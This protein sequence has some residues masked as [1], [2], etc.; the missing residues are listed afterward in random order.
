L[1]NLQKRF[2][3]KNK[4][5]EEKS[6]IT[7]FIDKETKIKVLEYGIILP[8]RRT[9]K[10]NGLVSATYEGGVSDK[11]GNFVAGLIRNLNNPNFNYNCNESYKVKKDNLEYS[12]ETVIFGGILFK[13]F[14][15]VYLDTL[16]RLWWVI[17]NPDK[18]YRLVFV[19]IPNQEFWCYDFFDMLN[20]PRNRIVI[21]NKPT[22]FKKIIIPD[23][24]I[25]SQSGFKSEFFTII[26]TISSSVKPSPYKKIYLTRSQLEEKDCINEEYFENFYKKRGYKVISPEKYSVKEQIAFM[27]GAE[28]VV[29]TVGTLSHNILFSKKNITL[30]MLTRVDNLLIPQI[31]INEIKNI[32]YFIIDVTKNIL[33]TTHVKGCF[34]LH[35]SKFWIEYLDD[36]KIDYMK[37]EIEFDLDEFL[38]IYLKQWCKNYSLKSR[39]RRIERNDI[40]HVINSLSIAFYDKSLSRKNMD[41]PKIQ[42]K[43]ALIR[44]NKKLKIEI[45][46]LKK[47]KK[48]LSRLYI[49]LRKKLKNYYIAQKLYSIFKK[50]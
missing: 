28:E 10:S 50:K 24:S 38:P 3:T 31:I 39:Y 18:N 30:T 48:I 40:F 34:L 13:S 46:T 22:K 26:D 7:Y 15:H 49:I 32:N 29:S 16:T 8:L 12:D 19:N 17:K 5:W 37:E 2:Y 4:K 23:E 36:N 11:K 9:K 35:P 33:P 41:S 25:H 45:D 6:Q 1:Q 21:L 42:S 20:I 43:P 47:Q 14:G 44:E 27:A